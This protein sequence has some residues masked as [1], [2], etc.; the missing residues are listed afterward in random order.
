MSISAIVPGPLNPTSPVQNANQL[1][2]KAFQ[3]LTQALSANLTDVA[4]T[5]ETLRQSVTSLTTTQS[6]QLT[7][8][9]KTLGV[10]LQSSDLAGA[11]NVYSS[12]QQNAPKGTDP[13]RAAHH[14]HHRGGNGSQTLTS[15]FPNAGGSSGFS[16][17]DA[18][19]FFQPVSLTV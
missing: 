19:D 3:Q 10:A 8:A 17:A 7:Q 15:G 16:A 6:A 9:L 1:A 11:L 2:G 4:P 14:H 12:E 13:I 18:N 5:S